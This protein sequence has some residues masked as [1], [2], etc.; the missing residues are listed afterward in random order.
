MSGA[1]L[2]DWDWGQ[3]CQGFP[4]F[5][6][7]LQLESRRCLSSLQKTFGLVPELARSLRRR[8]LLT[9]HDMQ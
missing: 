7:E 3:E 4:N 5:G 8:V 6:L 2:L 1:C 9:L